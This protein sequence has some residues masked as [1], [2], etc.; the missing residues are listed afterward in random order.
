VTAATPGSE[1]LEGHL[2]DALETTGVGLLALTKSGLHPEPAVV[3]VDR[4]RGRLWFAIL[5]DSELVR[6][7]G[8]GGCAIF[9]VQGRG[10]LASVG[11]ALRPED[12]PHR[13]ARLWTAAAQAWRPQGPSDPAL[14]L[15][16]M[17]CVDAELTRADF[18]LRRYAWELSGLGSRQPAAKSIPP[19]R[20]TLH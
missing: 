1:T 13:L 4:R 17:D 8:D 18:G 19:W 14:I 11:G 12:A 10:L 7:L 3:F 6:S 16:R 9:T 2:W 15:L 20:P 5:G